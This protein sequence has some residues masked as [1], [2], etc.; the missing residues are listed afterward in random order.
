M[1]HQ[2]YRAVHDWFGHVVPGYAFGIEGEIEAFHIHTR[3]FSPEVLKIVFS[4]VVLANAYYELHADREDIERYH[5]VSYTEF[6]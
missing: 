2:R 4:D 1:Y 6:F 3:M 5:D